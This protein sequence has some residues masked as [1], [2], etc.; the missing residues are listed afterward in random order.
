M[1]VLNMVADYFQKCAFSLVANT[2]VGKK[3]YLKKLSG[4]R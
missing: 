4:L 1:Y 2:G 3:L